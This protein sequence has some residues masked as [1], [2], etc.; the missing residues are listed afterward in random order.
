[1]NVSFWD[2][3]WFLIIVMLLAWITCLISVLVG[4]YLVFRTKRD[5]FEPFLPKRQQAQVP[6]NL[7]EADYSTHH[8]SESAA[9]APPDDPMH[10]VFE[11]FEKQNEEFLK[12]MYPHNDGVEKEGTD[13]NV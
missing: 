2:I 13:E 4:G 9:A 8:N 12:K 1:M 5:A 11:R 7:D 6:I 10:V 3:S